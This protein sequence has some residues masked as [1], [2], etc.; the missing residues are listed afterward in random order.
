MKP[1]TLEQF[2]TQLAAMLRRIPY[3]ASAD[4]TDY[5]IAF[6]DGA[7]VVYAFIS[8]NDGTERI[9]DE[10]ELGEYEWNHWHED[11]ANWISE[12]VFSVRADLHK[13]P[14]AAPADTD[15]R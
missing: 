12:P 15:V 9:D 7:R 11:F 3:G 2:K 14:L 13:R 5:A 1:L 10:F 4:L 8:D 6:W